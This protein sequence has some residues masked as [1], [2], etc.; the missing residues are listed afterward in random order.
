MRKFLRI[1]FICA[2]VLTTASY[3]ALAVDNEYENDIVDRF[4][5]F[6]TDAYMGTWD[7]GTTAYIAL[8]EDDE[9]GV[10]AVLVLMDPA[11]GWSGNYIG[12]FTEYERA[13]YAFEY[14]S[15]GLEITIYIMPLLDG[16]FFFEICCG[17]IDIINPVEV[18]E[19]IEAFLTVEKETENMAYARLINL[20]D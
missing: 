15:C 6:L 8:G 16:G 19:V 9:E 4:Y 11:N 12:P 3:P 13:L 17:G 1:F 18:D 2:L 14:N 10:I 5:L 7:D 20:S